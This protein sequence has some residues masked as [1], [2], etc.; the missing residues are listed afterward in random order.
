M[1]SADFLV[2]ICFLL[3]HALTGG[4]GSLFLLFAL[5]I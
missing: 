2:K 1:L 5:Y 4:M 3:H